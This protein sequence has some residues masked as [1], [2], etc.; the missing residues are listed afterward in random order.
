[1]TRLVLFLCLC[2]NVSASPLYSA[3][4][5]CETLAAE[6]SRQ[7]GL[8]DGLLAAI[9]RTESGIARGQTDLRAW[10]WAANVQGESHYYDTSQD[11]LAHLDRV[12]AADISNFDVGCMQLNYHW[13]GEEFSDLDRML[14]PETN[15]SYAARYLKRLYEETGSWDTAT[16]Y[17]HS[18][19]P[20]RG[21]AYLER[22]RQMRASLA[23]PG[24]DPVRPIAVV[25]SAPS[26]KRFQSHR[27][28]TE[29]IELR[30]YWERANLAE[31][32][33]PRLP[34]RP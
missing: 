30:A 21:G 17:Y 16:Q 20:D 4:P 19:D 10:P 15:V 6:A 28:M 13:H 12:R 24:S 3:P 2:L 8:P 29:Q 22:V 14:D 23:P 27:S 11:M 9:A 26:D 5:D 32:R 7:Y 31:G 34:G 25:A 18:R 33:L 1:M